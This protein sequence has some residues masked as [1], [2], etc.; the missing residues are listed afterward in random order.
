MKNFRGLSIA[1]AMCAL[2]AFADQPKAPR[3]NPARP[4][5]STA[6]TTTEPS[7]ATM[8][9][10]TTEPSTAATAPTTST[11]NSS[12]TTND[13]MATSTATTPST[14]TRSRSLPRTASDLPL[15]VIIGLLALG[16]ALTVRSIARR[17]A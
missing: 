8:P 16:G 5:P 1:L 15:L 9:A 6:T 12:T 2:P 11:Y 7:T 3:T 13:S 17:E 14:P 4:A 10:T